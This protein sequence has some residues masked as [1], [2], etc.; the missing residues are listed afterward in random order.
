MYILPQISS[1]KHPIFQI[2]ILP[3]PPP[4]NKFPPTKPKYQ[5]ST[6]L[7]SPS[8]S[9]IV[10]VQGNPVLLPLQADFSDITLCKF[11]KWD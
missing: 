2:S 8:L 11:Y 6:P 3:H 10:G 5:T 1:D 7:L 9:F 4:P